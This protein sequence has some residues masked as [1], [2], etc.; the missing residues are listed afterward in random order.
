MF[1]LEQRLEEMIN[2]STVHENNLLCFH[3]A[4]ALLVW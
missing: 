1:E 4:Q 2:Y 3:S